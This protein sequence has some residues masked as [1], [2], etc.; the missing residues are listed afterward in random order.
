VGFPRRGYSKGNTNE[1]SQER[2]FLVNA[3]LTVSLRIGRAFATIESLRNDKTAFHRSATV[4]EKT[5]LNQRVSFDFSI[6]ARSIIP[7]KV[8]KCVVEITRLKI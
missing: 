4:S 1:K 3:A 2:Y 5:L 8:D 6:A 7:R